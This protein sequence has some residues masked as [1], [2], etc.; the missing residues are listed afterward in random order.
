ML[1]VHHLRKS[2]G[3]EGTGS[4][5]SGALAGFVDVI[6]ELRRVKATADPG[7][8]K[9]CLTG[10][11]RYDAIPQEW[12]VELVAEAGGGAARPAFE[13]RPPKSD[14]AARAEREDARQ[15]EL[16]Q[17]LLWVI[18]TAEEGGGLTRK[19]IWDALPEGLRVNEARF[20]EM[21]EAGAGRDW[22]R[23]GSGG[24]GHPFRYR[25]VSDGPTEGEMFGAAACRTDPV[26]EIP[27]SPLRLG[28]F[29]Q[30]GPA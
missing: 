19:Q 28:D 5:G 7:Q 13:H 17:A 21:L 23:E 12:V 29:L 2:D 20:K 30:D 11:G 10:Y 1:L 9:R 25:R 14:A 22:L 18:P 6:V 27:Q 3:L 16:R 15:D 26:T 8:R 24:K 4:R